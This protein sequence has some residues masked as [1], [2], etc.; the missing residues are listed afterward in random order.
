LNGVIQGSAADIMKLKLVE[1]YKTRKETG[2]IL[3]MT[4]HDEVCGD[5]PDVESARKVDE[6]LNSQSGFVSELRVPILWDTKFGANW[7]ECK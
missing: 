5:V 3:R 4:V 2:L 6:V 1:L 7:K